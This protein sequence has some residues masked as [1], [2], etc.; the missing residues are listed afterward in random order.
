MNAASNLALITGYYGLGR[1]SADKLK[2]WHTW[3]PSQ[4][5]ELIN[6][7]RTGVTTA[8]LTTSLYV[9]DVW[10]GRSSLQRSNKA[11][12]RTSD[13]IYDQRWYRTLVDFG[14]SCGLT[15]DE[16]NYYL[17]L[18]PILEGQTPKQ[19]DGTGL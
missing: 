14:K 8:P 15:E 9:Q 18:D 3:A 4:L 11:W 5:I 12:T 10:N 7:T 13:P 17:T 1:P 16:F 6:A 2:E 19:L